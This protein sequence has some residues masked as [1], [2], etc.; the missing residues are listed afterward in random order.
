MKNIPNRNT[1][2]FILLPPMGD[3]VLESK[4]LESVLHWSICSH[5]SSNNKL[6]TQRATRWQK[7]SAWGSTGLSRPTS[8]W[9]RQSPLSPRL[10]AAWRPHWS[11]DPGLQTSG[12]WSRTWVGILHAEAREVLFRS[13]RSIASGGARN[14]SGRWRAYNI[15]SCQSGPSVQG[16][17]GHLKKWR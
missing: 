5:T 10:P 6:L 9:S 7:R 14:R 4:H 15:L 16:Q 13:T 8:S 17:G 12:T 3:I 11:R 2:E 1:R